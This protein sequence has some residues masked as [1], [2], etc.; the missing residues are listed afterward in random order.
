MARFTAGSASC[1]VRSLCLPRRHPG[2]TPSADQAAVH[3]ASCDLHSMRCTPNISLTTLDAK[4][5]RSRDAPHGNDGQ[6]SIRNS[7]TGAIRCART[8]T[9]SRPTVV[10]NHHKC[11]YARL[12]FTAASR[13]GCAASV[14]AVLIIIVISAFYIRDGGIHAV[15]RTGKTEQAP[16]AAAL[17]L[18]SG[19]TAALREA[20]NWS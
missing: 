4:R 15:A 11:S 12:G 20:R 16:V 10:L 3:P 2:S 7:T 19:A 5:T 18:V 8:L 9:A 13:S 1:E 6:H 14:Y 17:Y